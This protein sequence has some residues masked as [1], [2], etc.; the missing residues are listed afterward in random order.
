M[1]STGIWYMSYAT[2]LRSAPN[3]MT[4]INGIVTNKRPVILIHEWN[5]VNP[6]FALVNA[7][8]LE[9]ADIVALVEGGYRV[10]TDPVDLDLKKLAQLYSGITNTTDV[11]KGPLR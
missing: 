3:R 7:M 11:V 2:I 5:S 6:S 10:K 4:E 8:E 9:R 1:S